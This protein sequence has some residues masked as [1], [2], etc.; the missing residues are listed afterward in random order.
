MSA[1]PKAPSGSQKKNPNAWMEY[2]AIL[3]KAGY[4]KQVQIALGKALPLVPAAMRSQFHCQS[5]RI[6]RLSWQLDHALASFSKA[7]KDPQHKVHALTGL[8]E[9]YERRS[10]LD[11][12]AELLE[13]IPTQPD[14]SLVHARILRRLG[15]LEEAGKLLDT[16]PAQGPRIPESLTARVWHERYL[17]ADQSGDY[18]LAWSHL[19]Q[20]KQ[21]IRQSWQGPQFAAMLTQRR[22]AMAVML[23]T[24]QQLQPETVE[25]WISE[26][27]ALGQPPLGF[28]LGLPRSGTTLVEKLLSQQADIV[29][30]DERDTLAR[31]VLEPLSTRI[32]TTADPQ[33]DA[34]HFL[35]TL[36]SLSPAF[37]KNGTKHY[38]QELDKQLPH[39]TAGRPVL[40]KNPGYSESAL[41]IA[42]LCPGARIIYPQR[43]PPRRLL[44][45]LGTLPRAAQRDQHLLAAAGYPRRVDEPHP[46][47][48]AAPPPP[49]PRQ[50]LDRSP[51]R[52][53][54]HPP[55]GRSHPPV[56]L[57]RPPL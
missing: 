50:P 36:D 41:L 32:T 45:H 14:G 49:P 56:H 53:P 13:G 6:Y 54:R 11:K 27:A 48:L 35:S 7:L 47:G 9:C 12:A 17:L 42:R 51:L 19:E 21:T 15:R 33:A 25:R 57:P 39:K 31:S 44:L 8:A 18:P 26:N 43:D 20:C 52:G 29:T 34:A 23:A 1:E 3:A 22:H 30:T 10:Q 46:P 37:I 5:G 16:I 40:D 55:A 24:L 4:T 38:Y 2:A 28:I